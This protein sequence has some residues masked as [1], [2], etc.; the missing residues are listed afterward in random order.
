MPQTRIRSV[1][2]SRACRACPV[3]RARPVRLCG[4]TGF[5]GLR[6]MRSRSPSSAAGPRVPGGGWNTHPRDATASR[7][8]HGGRVNR[9]PEG[10]RKR[11]LPLLRTRHHPI[12]TLHADDPGRRSGAHQAQHRFGQ[13]NLLI[14]RRRRKAVL[15]CWQAPIPELPGSPS[16]DNPTVFWATLQATSATQATIVRYPQGRQPSCRSSG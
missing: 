14:P 12:Q 11:R 2:I 16:G 6:R 7:C 10:V 15:E 3:R 1:G 9:G 5:S 8:L 4:G 13:R